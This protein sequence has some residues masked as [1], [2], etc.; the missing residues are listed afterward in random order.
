MVDAKEQLRGKKWLSPERGRQGT[1]RKQVSA[2]V[3]VH[4]LRTPSRLNMSIGSQSV[5]GTGG[6]DPNQSG[7]GV[8]SNLP[9]RKQTVLRIAAENFHLVKRLE[10]V[11]SAIGPGGSQKHTAVSLD[12]RKSIAMAYPNILDTG[13]LFTLGGVTKTPK[14]KRTQT[15]RQPLVKLAPL[16]PQVATSEAFKDYVKNRK[17]HIARKREYDSKRASSKPNKLPSYGSPIQEGLPI[18]KNA[19]KRQLVPMTKNQERTVS[20][21][22]FKK[23]LGHSATSRSLNTS[24]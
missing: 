2:S 4:G 12:R 23:R 11:R 19:H 10:R 20:M 1:H 6:A 3:E 24:V 5:R 9:E 14:F 13:R 7:R 21:M 22:D 18:L 8:M 16:D 17:D 15:L